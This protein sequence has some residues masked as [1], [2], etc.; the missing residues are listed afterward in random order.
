MSNEERSVTDRD[1]V[2]TGG[3]QG[4]GGRAGDGMDAGRGGNADAPSDPVVADARD[5]LDLGG[6]GGT[7]MGAVP[8]GTDDLM[9]EMGAEGTSGPG[10]EEGPI[11]AGTPA[12]AGDGT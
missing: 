3:G 11:G 10:S 9:S 2:R 12:D 6:L 8:G 4:T 1:E 5:A 7:A